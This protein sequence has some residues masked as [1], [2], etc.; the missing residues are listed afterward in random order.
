MCVNYLKRKDFGLQKLSISE[1]Q[2]DLGNH[3]V[4]EEPH[5]S[6]RLSKD[7]HKDRFFF[8]VIKEFK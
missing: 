6:L 4:L 3:K 5:F 1:Q 2:K 7:F 8:S